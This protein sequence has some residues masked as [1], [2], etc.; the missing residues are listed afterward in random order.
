MSIAPGIPLHLTPSLSTTGSHS[1][2]PPPAPAPSSSP[3]SP[4]S[5]CDIVSCASSPAPVDLEDLISVQSRIARRLPPIVPALCP[6]RRH[7]VSGQTYVYCSCGRSKTQPW[8]DDSHL[9]TDPQPISFTVPHSNSGYSL[10]C[11]CKYT[12]NPPFCDGSHIHPN[13]GTEE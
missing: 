8:C 13:K 11:G 10:I 12:A 9:P 5:H 3:L 6:Y 2:A 4:Q 1:T 7:L